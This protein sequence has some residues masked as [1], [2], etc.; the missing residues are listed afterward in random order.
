MSV[1]HHITADNTNVSFH[2][3]S[4]I[5]KNDILNAIQNLQAMV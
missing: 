5:T 1:S 3:N 4:H 2:M